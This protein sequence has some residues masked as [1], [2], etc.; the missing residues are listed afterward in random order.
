MLSASL[1]QSYEHFVN[2]LMFRR[3][4]LTLDDDVVATMN[5]KEFQKISEFKDEGEEGLF[6]RKKLSK[7]SQVP[8]MKKPINN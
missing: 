4:I 5:F 6:V 3:D 7:R 2:T 1:L 8:Q